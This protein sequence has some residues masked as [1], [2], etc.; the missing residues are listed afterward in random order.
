MNKEKNQGQIQ[1]VQ[2]SSTQGSG[3]AEIDLLE[4]ALKLLECWKSVATGAL[5]GALIMFLYSFF[6]ATP[7]YEA[8]SKIYV[9]SSESTF[10][11]SDFQIS[12]YLTGDYTQV[13]D[14]WEVKEMVRQNL[15]LDYTYAQ[16]G[17]MLRVSN[18]S[19]T[20]I[21]EIT[22]ARPDPNEAA[23]IANE[24]ADVA[25]QYIS[26]VM[27]TDEPSLLSEAKVPEN[28]VSP[29]KVRNVAVGFILGAFLV[30]VL[31]VAKFL[32]DDR[33]MT[34]E[35]IRKYVGLP[36]LALIPDANDTKGLSSSGGYQKGSKS[37]RRN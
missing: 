11:L 36:T 27:K 25:R 24:Y 9:I 10:S 18:P 7:M 23:E 14:T 20:R 32:I 26:A 19:D 28:P 30:S 16:L 4:L 17:S 13:F 34:A 21:L 22:V 1:W 31:V 37:S 8:T 6:I 2:S 35:D 3:E 12:N 15:E 33:I 5:L 29:K